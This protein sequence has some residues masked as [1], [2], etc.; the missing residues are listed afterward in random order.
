MLLK[1]AAE[2]ARAGTYVMRTLL[3]LFVQKVVCAMRVC[4]YVFSS[5]CQTGAYMPILTDEAFVIHITRFCDAF[6]TSLYPL[7]FHLV[8]YSSDLLPLV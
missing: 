1:M 6:D 5:L 8:S 4:M 2:A 7:K 3:L